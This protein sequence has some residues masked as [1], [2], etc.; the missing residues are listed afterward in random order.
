MSGR[1]TRKRPGKW[2]EAPGEVP[3]E[4]GLAASHSPATSAHDMSGYWD[5]KT[6]NARREIQFRVLAP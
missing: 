3:S 2:G 4:P 6:E 1:L 5:R